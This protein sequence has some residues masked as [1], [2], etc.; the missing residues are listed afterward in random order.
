MPAKINR[1]RKTAKVQDTRD[2][3]IIWRDAWDE[4]EY[5][6][7]VNAA[8]WADAILHQML[9]QHSGF[10]FGVRYETKADLGAAILKRGTSSLPS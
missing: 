7:A 5:I 6:E 10:F 9:W 8:P 2:R 3:L 4:E 1:R